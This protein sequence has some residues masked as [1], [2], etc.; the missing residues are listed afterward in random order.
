MSGADKPVPGASNGMLS[1][2]AA[3]VG[4]SSLP[5]PGSSP[6]SCNQHLEA[7]VVRRF[8]F[9]CG[10]APKGW[11]RGASEEADAGACCLHE[12]STSQVCRP[13]PSPATH[14][15]QVQQLHQFWNPTWRCVRR[16]IPHPHSNTCCPCLFFPWRLPE[17]K[18]FFPRRLLKWTTFFPHALMP[19]ANQDRQSSS[20]APEEDPKKQNA[21]QS[22]ATVGFQD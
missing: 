22:F 2:P 10:E 16:P 19:D 14:H 6:K 17:W 18:T 4:S 21:I 5:R 1:T 12:G 7:D 13:F 15:F 8:S 9:S 20:C 11:T 3:D